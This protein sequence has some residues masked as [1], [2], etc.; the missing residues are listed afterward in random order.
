MYSSRSRAD[1]NLNLIQRFLTMMG[2]VVLILGLAWTSRSIIDYSLSKS[3]FCPHTFKPSEVDHY[4]KIESCQKDDEECNRY[5]GCLQCP[6][7]GICLENGTLAGCHG[8]YIVRASSCVENE[9]ITEA[10]YQALN[11]GLNCFYIIYSS[12]SW[13]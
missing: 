13:S 2:F 5:R 3:K 12:L 8:A 11:V 9:A 4:Q 10:A 7:H 6:N 1:E